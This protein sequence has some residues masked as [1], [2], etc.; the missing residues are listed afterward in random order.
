[1]NIIIAKLIGVLA[2]FLAGK[3]MKGGGFGFWVDTLLIDYCK[4]LVIN[5]VF[6]LFLAHFL[7]CLTQI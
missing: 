1:M 3:L 4:L 5:N 2:G 6:F 7:V